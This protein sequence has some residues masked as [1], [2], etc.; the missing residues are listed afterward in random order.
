M[1]G[2]AGVPLLPHCCC[3]TRPCAYFSVCLLP[4]VEKQAILL[5]SF[6]S[7][8]FF[9]LLLFV[10]RNVKINLIKLIF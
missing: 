2:V 1:Q 3:A 7:R 10:F 8:L 4:S 9:F 6:T 5:L